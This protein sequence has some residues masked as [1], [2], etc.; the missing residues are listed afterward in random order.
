VLSSPPNNAT[1]QPIALNLVWFKSTTATSYRVQLAT[2]SKFNSGIIVNDSTLTDSIRAV[3]GLNYSTNYWWRVNAKNSA[4]TSAYSSVWK[5]TTGPL[6]PAVLNLNVIPGGFYNTS[7]GRLNMRD[8]ITAVLVDSATCIK[9]DSAKGV[10]DSVNFGV[11][12]SF[13]NVVTGN[14]YLIIYHRNHLAV[15]SRLRT[16]ITRGSTVSYNFTT[17]SAKAFGFNM[18]KVST[19]PVRWGMI[20]GDANRDGFVDGL[21]QTIWI[22]QN[23]F[24]GYLSADFNGDR[25]VD[26][27]DQTIWIIYNGNGSFL[28]CGLFLDPVTKQLQGTNPNYDAKKGNRE[29]FEIFRREEKL[30]NNKK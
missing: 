4:G 6:P 27:L 21:D 11:N 23:G 7:T 24:D 2:D 25:F 1:N 30:N 13:A 10:L 28:P 14:Y 17:D 19:S 3:S 5:F 20:P 12:I 8:T 16:P 29:L 15:S 22:G 18:I 26:G 9:V